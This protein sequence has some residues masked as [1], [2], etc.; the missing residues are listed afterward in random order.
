[1]IPVVM[2]YCYAKM[3]DFCP[4]TKM[5]TETRYK[6]SPWSGYQIIKHKFE[7]HQGFS[8]VMTQWPSWNEWL[9]V[10][11]ANWKSL[12]FTPGE[13]SFDHLRRAKS[14]RY[15]PQLPEW[16]FFMLYNRYNV[17]P[18]TI[19]VAPTVNTK[20]P[21]Q[22]RKPWYGCECTVQNFAISLQKTWW[23]KEML[24]HNF[25]GKY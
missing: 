12:N 1:M 7:T 8:E 2:C 3:I 16:S 9:W 20:S 14:G 21:C 4:F 18:P 24:I 5:D 10:C 22:K 6:G 19:I 17:N 15:D 23:Q 11:M 13:K 25:I